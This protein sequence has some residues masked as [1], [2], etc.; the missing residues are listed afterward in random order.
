MRAAELLA[1]GTNLQEGIG[2]IMVVDIGGATTDIDSVAVGTPTKSGV[3]LKD[4]RSLL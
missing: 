4:L 2:E 1:K 3:I